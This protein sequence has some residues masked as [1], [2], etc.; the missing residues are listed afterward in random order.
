M[1]KIPTIFHPKW[2]V[3]NNISTS[4]INVPMQTNLSSLEYSKKYYELNKDKIC[5]KRKIEYNKNKQKKKE[6]YQKKKEEILEK[7]K[8]E[9]QK[10]INNINI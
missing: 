5:E 6:Y 4:T 3:K 7:R 2:L 8:L 1:D 9:Y 10:K